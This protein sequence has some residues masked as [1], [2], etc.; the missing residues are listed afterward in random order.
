[1]TWAPGGCLFLVFAP[2][3]LLSI[4]FGLILEAVWLLRGLRRQTS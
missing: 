1:M 4:V 3:G 2:L